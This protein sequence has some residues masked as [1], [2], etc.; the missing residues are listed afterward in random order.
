[1][2]YKNIFEN[3][4]TVRDFK[5]TKIKPEI[6]ESLKEYGDKLALPKEGNF[7]VVSFDGE[8][9]YAALNGK[10]GY[11]GKLIEAPLYIAVV[12]D[13][14]NTLL[15]SGYFTE[16]IRL[17]IQDMNLGSCW[18]SVE[19]SSPVEEFIGFGKVFTVIAVGEIYNGIFKKDIYRKSD[20]NAVSDIVYNEKWGNEITWEDLNSKGLDEVF[21]FAR[22]APSWGNQQPWKFIIENSKIYLLVKKDSDKSFEL[23]SGII[24]FFL[25]KAFIAVGITVIADYGICDKNLEQPSNYYICSVFSM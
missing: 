2:N 19:D 7:K 3:L 4:K 11:F 9:G 12:G 23:E 13:E 8:T 21:Y 16:A 22:L 5:K 15:D 25:E 18:I 24:S 17:K 14:N 20:R 6:I 1:M 10:I